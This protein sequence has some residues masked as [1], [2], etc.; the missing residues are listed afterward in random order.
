V[1][2]SRA[3]ASSAVVVVAVS[4]VAVSLDTVSLD[5]VSLDTVP[6]GTGAAVSS[7]GSRG[8]ASFGSRGT[9]LNCL[10]GKAAEAVGFALRRSSIA[11][12]T[13]SAT[14]TNVSA[15]STPY[16]A[17]A[18]RPDANWDAKRGMQSARNETEG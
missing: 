1:G 6:F 10:L 8:T 9:A 7:T 3:G 13:T 11:R 5:T 15:M 18:N 17:G 12:R 2:A 16:V 14:V 4:L